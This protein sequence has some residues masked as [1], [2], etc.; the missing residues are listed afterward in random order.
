MLSIKYSDYN[1][2]TLEVFWYNCFFLWIFMISMYISLTMSVQI[3]Q[4]VSK[5][6]NYFRETQ[7]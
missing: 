2:I 3:L 5:S 7:S 6:I 4:N 1:L